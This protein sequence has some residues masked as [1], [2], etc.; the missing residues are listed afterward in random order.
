MQTYSTKYDAFLLVSFGGPEGMDEVMP[1]LRN[2]L[3]GRN[4]PEERMLAVAHH[5]ELFGGVSP[6]NE[7][8]RRLIAAL[9]PVIEFNGPKLPI[10]WGNRNWHP[11][12]TD[13]VKQ[14]T[15]DGIKRVVAFATSGYSSYSSCRQYLENIEAACQLAGP[16]APQIE[17]IK[18]FYNHPDFIATNV[19]NLLMALSSISEARRA[20]AEIVFTAH[21]IPM[22][23]ANACLY[24]SQLKETAK[25][26]MQESGLNNNWCLAYQSRSGPL[27]QPWLEPDINLC[28]K[29]IA[30]NNGQD[31]LIAPIGF[32]SD[33]MEILFDLDTEAKQLCQALNIGYSRA[34][35]AGTH[36]RFISMIKKLVES[37]IE[38]ISIPPI[39]QDNRPNG[40]LCQPGCCLKG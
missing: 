30:Q 28:I 29:E 27:S 35:T 20:A 10:Y 13:T 32:V 23:M 22:T 17:K 3:R 4:V 2:V 1:F 9:S 25:L 31:V 5:Y 36:P 26:V 39:A 7:Q 37:K 40:L 11:L 33:H 24:E 18:P 8:N 6:I 15:E 21:S 14:M 19:D 34:K 16:N 38:N 12:L